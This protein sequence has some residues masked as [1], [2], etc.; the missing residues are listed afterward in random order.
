MIQIAPGKFIVATNRHELLQSLKKVPFIEVSVVEIWV[1]HRIG[2]EVERL[3]K[4]F[5]CFTRADPKLIKGLIRAK[6]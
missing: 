3:F 6:P 1:C 5:F 2:R 4:V